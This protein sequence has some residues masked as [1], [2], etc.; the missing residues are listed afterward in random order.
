MPGFC[1]SSAPKPVY[2]TSALSAG[3]QALPSPM[4]RVL[5]ESYDSR[6]FGHSADAFTDWLNARWKKSGYQ[7]S[8]E[9]VCFTLRSHGRDARPGQVDKTGGTFYR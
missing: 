5:L 9:V 4:V 8:K 3:H 2:T 6:D 7:V 1:R